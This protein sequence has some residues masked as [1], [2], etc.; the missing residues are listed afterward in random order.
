MK[1]YDI[2]Y[3]LNHQEQRDFISAEG[4]V[5]TDAS[6]RKYV[7]MDDMCI[8]LGQGNRA[9]TD[10]MTSALNGI[11][12]GKLGYSAPKERLHQY[13]METTGGA[14]KAVHLTS[15]GSEAAEWAVKLAKKMTG[16]TEVISFWN[17][18]HGRTQLSAGMSGL[19]RRKTGF[20]PVEPGVIFTPYPN[21][22]SKPEGMTDEAYSREFIEK[23]EQKYNYESAHDAACVIAESVQG[24]GVI[25]PPK[26]FLKMLFDW[27]HE[28]GMLFIADEIQMGMGRTG[29]MYRYSSEGFIPDM[30][31]LGKALGN[32]LHISALLVR[33]LPPESALPALSGGV[34]DDVL[35]CTAAC[36]VYRQLE[37]G[38]LEHVREMG[39]LIEAEFSKLSA[40]EDILQVRCAGLADA[41][42]YRSES[43]CLKALEGLR[44][45]GFMPGRF[46]NAIYIKPPYTVTE[47]QI[48]TFAAL[49]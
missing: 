30:L 4:N 24:G 33:E 19:P 26:G 7:D 37:N 35:A 47:E 20:G 11:T 38:L 29:E 42:E 16:R 46:G 21:A 44:A 23:L 34:G 27:A 48:R 45:A 22:A 39:K 8:V 2:L 12:S 6:G 43:A 13:M 28:K 18:I 31:L 17:S 41:V 40:R 10:V 15:S 9:F 3:P 1:N 36:E 5:F 14:F 49:L 32:G 25:V